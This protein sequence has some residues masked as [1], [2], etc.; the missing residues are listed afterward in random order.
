M[1]SLQAA[2]LWSSF[3]NA[4]FQRYIHLNFRLRRYRKNAQLRKKGEKDTVDDYVN[5]MVGPHSLKTS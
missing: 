1:L 2:K 5:K 4:S 3:P